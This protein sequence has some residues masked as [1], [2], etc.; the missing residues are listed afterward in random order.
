MIKLFIKVSLA[1]SLLFA[2][3]SQATILPLNVNDL[4]S[5]DYIVYNYDGVDYDIA[6]VSD[7]SS[8][9]WFI[10]SD[11]NYNLLFEADYHS[12]WN[13]AGENGIPTI[14]D[15][16]S[17]ISGEQLLAKFKREGQFVQ[18]FE[19]WNSVFN[20]VLDDGDNLNNKEISSM[21]NW[22]IPL[23]MDIEALSPI[24]KE[25]LDFEISDSD[26]NTFYDTFY[27]R[28][29]VAQTDDSTPVP[30]PSTLMIF[31]LGLIALAS[32]KRLFS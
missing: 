8:E 25:D 1:L 17:D 16:F 29:S 12:G 13:F 5:D 6:W 14:D 27:F 10:D 21:W 20:T 26:Q 30:E 23:D 22:N 31:A 7:V 3:V 24:E 15:I 9:I 32:K 2:G 18:A 19:Y 4:T 28:A 11:Y